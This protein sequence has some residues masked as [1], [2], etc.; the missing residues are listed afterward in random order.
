MT[1]FPVA[2]VAEV[3]VVLV[4]AATLWRAARL[5]R[6]LGALRGER[7]ALI[8]AMHGFEESADLA[9]KGVTRLRELSD[10]AERTLKD[11][12]GAAETLQSDL[13]YM[14]ERGVA[15]ADRL[16]EIVRDARNAAAALP[17]AT[18]PVTPAAPAAAAPAAAAPEPPP[19][20]P[21]PERPIDNRE[22]QMLRALG[23]GR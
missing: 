7:G 10:G 1:D 15:L 20:P 12:V 5:E 18:D 4:L 6:V 14:I 13:A 16:E 19:P 8:E 17:P 21:L 11:R 9:A 3:G 2:I 22:R 23:L